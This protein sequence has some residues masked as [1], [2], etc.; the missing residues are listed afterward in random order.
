MIPRTRTLIVAAAGALTEYLATQFDAAGRII[1]TA[2]ATG[3][4]AGIVQRA[5]PAL[6]TVDVISGGPSEALTGAAL[7]KGTHMAL[8][9]D[10]TGRLIPFVAGA[11]NVQVAIW[12]PE[13]LPAN[14]GA[15]GIS[16]RV[17]VTGHILAGA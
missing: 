2:G 5:V 15:A 17:F 16:I 8:M 7:T 10:A 4:F 1:Q 12:E 3:P 11:G 13:L 14:P 6:G 9:C